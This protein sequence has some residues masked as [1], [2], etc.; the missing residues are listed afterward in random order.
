VAVLR[1]TSVV[2]VVLV[3]ALLIA[4]AFATVSIAQQGRT[5]VSKSDPLYPAIARQMHLNGTVKVKAVIAAD[6]QVKEIEVIG[7]HPLLAEATLEALKRWRYAPSS[8]ESPITLEFHF[9]P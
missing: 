9:Q 5:L 3:P 6:G 1:K 7:G 8:S 2:C 4:L